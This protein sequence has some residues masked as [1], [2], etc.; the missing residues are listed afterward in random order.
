MS[1]SDEKGGLAEELLDLLALTIVLF[2]FCGSHEAIFP[3]EC[4]GEVRQANSLHRNMSRRVHGQD[5]EVSFTFWRDTCAFVCITFSDCCTQLHFSFACG[6]ASLMVVE[7]MECIRARDA[8]TCID[9]TAKFLIICTSTLWS[10]DGDFLDRV[11]C[12]K[13]VLV[14]LG[15]S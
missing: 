14:A 1:A 10:T 12:C 9:L 11:I 2:G 3:D 4:Q 8:C 15:E 7:Q 6:I 13:E 5:W